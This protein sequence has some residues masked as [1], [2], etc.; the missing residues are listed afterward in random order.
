MR[1]SNLLNAGGQPPTG[2]G[3]AQG[4]G[5]DMRRTSAQWFRGRD[6]ETVEELVLTS[7]MLVAWITFLVIDGAS[8]WVIAFFALAGLAC[9]LTMAGSITSVERHG[10]ALVLN[11]TNRLWPVRVLLAPGQTVT[12][13][14]TL[15]HTGKGERYGDTAVYVDGKLV[16][17]IQAGRDGFIVRGRIDVA[18]DP[19]TAA[20]AA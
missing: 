7:A 1:I 5:A 12:F 10:D 4:G 8:A 3:T 14:R 19:M 13:E 11:R 6:G 17:F 9:N 2:M 15:E 18:D 20:P 16:T